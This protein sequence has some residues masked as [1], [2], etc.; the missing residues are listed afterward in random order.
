MWFLL[1]AGRAYH[2]FKSYYVSESVVAE[3]LYVRRGQTQPRQLS[4]RRAQHKKKPS[5]P[6]DPVEAD[7]VYAELIQ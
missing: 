5:C 3:G 7:K 6:P 1:V 4:K 2:R